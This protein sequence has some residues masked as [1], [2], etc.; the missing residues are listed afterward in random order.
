MEKQC[1]EALRKKRRELDYS[2]EYVA[3]KLGITQKAYSDIENGKTTLK[4]GI[5]LKLSKILDLNPDDLCPISN[6]CSHIYKAKNE[7]F[8]KLLKKNKIE[9]PKHLL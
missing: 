8:I 5:R 9:I 6:S 2:Q 4:D 7:E 1:L 3:G